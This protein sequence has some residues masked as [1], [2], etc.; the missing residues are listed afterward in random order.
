MPPPKDKATADVKKCVETE[1][2]ALNA[3]IKKPC[4]ELKKLD[5]EAEPILKKKKQDRSKDELKHLDIMAATRKSIRDKMMKEMRST[6]ARINKNI[7]SM[8]PPDKK[9]QKK[10]PLPGW[11]SKDGLRITDKVNLGGGVDL[12]KMK[13]SLELNGNFD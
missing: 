11:I 5:Q 9:E 10:L 7:R 8:P 4:A 3:K 13:F 12:K 6:E 1:L 2:K